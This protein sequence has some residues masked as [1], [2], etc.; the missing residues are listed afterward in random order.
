MNIKTKKIFVIKSA[1]TP[2]EVAN[3]KLSDLSGF[4]EDLVLKIQDK[5]KVSNVV[6]SKIFLKYYRVN[7]N[8]F[9]NNMWI[10][11]PHAKIVIKSGGETIYA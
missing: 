6:D 5:S 8:P 10:R 9:I 7:N 4:G 2:S 3:L 1:L 11:K